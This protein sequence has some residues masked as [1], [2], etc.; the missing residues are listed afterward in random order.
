MPE[1]EPDDH[2][3]HEHDH[4]ADE[5][6]AAKRVFKVNVEPMPSRFFIAELL[7]GGAARRP[8]RQTWTYLGSWRPSVFMKASTIS[9]FLI[10][11]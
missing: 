6:D 8:P 9:R 10:W 2:L 1:R 11:G 4:D 7:R 3:R 5:Q